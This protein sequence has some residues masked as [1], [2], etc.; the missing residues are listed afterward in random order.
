MAV[1]AAILLA[2]TLL[3]PAIADTVTWGKY[4]QN[5]NDT[6]ILGRLPDHNATDLTLEHCEI[7]E[8][9]PGDFDGLPNLTGIDLSNNK[10]QHLEPSEFTDVTQLGALFLTHNLLTEV[11]HFWKLSLFPNM[12]ILSLSNNKISTLDDPKTFSSMHSLK[13]LSLHTNGISYIHPDTFK[14]LTKLEIISLHN[15]NLQHIP[16]G[17]FHVNSLRII[18]L[19]NN[20]ISSVAP[21]AISSS[22]LES[23]LLKNNKLNYLPPRFVLKLKESSSSFDFFRFNGNPWQCACLLE[24]LA[25][26]NQTRVRY[27]DKADSCKQDAVPCDRSKKVLS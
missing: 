18:F 19:Q 11:P 20:V 10:L 6:R 2:A 1:V 13:I 15:N 5:F 14:H 4:K 25:E 16:D 9:K 12:T 22:K 8:L 26:V 24:V 23:L 7:T 21:D 3:S 27:S 17:T